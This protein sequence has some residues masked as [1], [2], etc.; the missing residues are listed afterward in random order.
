MPKVLTA[1][2]TLMLLLALLL[3]GCASVVP[4]DEPAAVHPAPPSPPAEPEA[5]AE[6][7]RVDPEPPV[8]QDPE[9]V[10]PAAEPAV[11]EAFEVTEEVFERTFSEVEQTIEELN[12]IIARRDY[13]RWLD[14]LT[15]E[16]RR[17]YSDPQILREISQMPI[18][19]RNEIELESLRD[20]FEWV[21]G[22]SRA[23]AR[24][25]DLRFLRDDQVEAIMVVRGQ[26]AILY[27]LR[28][29]AGSWKVDVF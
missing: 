17:T 21:V 6:P 13:Q 5:P 18:L 29:V 28:N 2:L 7:E 22:P 1:T 4:G 3:G 15:P 16:Y 24:L 26:P 9:P 27:L 8:A 11:E 14:Y 19:Q 23:N 20:Y 10:P 25:D 12:G